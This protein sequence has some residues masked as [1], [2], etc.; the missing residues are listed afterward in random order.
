MKHLQS[1]AAW[2]LIASVLSCSQTP[3]KIPIPGHPQVETDGR[4]E[5]IPFAGNFRV[6]RTTLSNGLKVMILRDQSSP[7]FA[8]QTW[9]KV[10]SRNEIPGKTGLAHLFEH[11]MFKGT[12]NHPQGEFD[13][14]LEQAGAE[15]ENAFTSNDH[16][17]YIQELPKAGF[18]LISSLEADRMVHLIVNEQSFNTEREVV[19]NERRFRKENSAEGTIYQTLLET[20]FTEHPYHWPVIGYEQDLNVMNANDAREF[21]EHYYSPDRAT[22]VVVGDVDPEDALRRIEKVYG[23]IPAKNLQDSPIK[24]EPRQ[25]AQRR[26]KLE[27]NIEVEKLWMAFK[28]PA[29]DSP[30]SPSLEAIQGLLSEGKNGRLKRALVDSGIAA[31]VSSGSFMMKEPGLFLIEADLQKGKSAL[32]AETVILREIERL[33]NSPVSLEELS[34][35]KNVMRFKFLEKLAT[36]GG[37]ANFIGQSESSVGSLERGIQLQNQI[38]DLN[39]EQIKETAVRHLDTSQMTVVVAVPKKRL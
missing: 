4:F 8:Y 6:H 17:V 16:T 22:V 28:V 7:T 2:I 15:G 3:K 18:N 12:T 29:A 25:T 31:S 24:P 27:L 37:K 39:P 5:V 38:Y 10:G 26:K 34:R 21:Y 32:L 20:A 13:A 23:G 36:A 33:K 11:M 30:D 14:L 19:Q 35:S 1:T 9:F